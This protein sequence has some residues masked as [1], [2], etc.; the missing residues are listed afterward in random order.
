MNL[1]TAG[2]GGWVAFVENL[3]KIH[4]NLGKMAPSVCRKTNENA[5]F[6]GHSKKGPRVLCERKSVGKV[7]QH[8]F[9]QVWVHLGK[10]PSRP[11]IYAYAQN[12]PNTVNHYHNNM[13]V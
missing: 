6:G 7:V 13:I 3:G 4:E 8:L 12:S 11:Q 1:K 9:G 5:L 10:N 2:V